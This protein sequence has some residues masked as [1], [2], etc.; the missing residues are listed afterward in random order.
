MTRRQ[1]AEFVSPG[2]ENVTVGGQ[3]YQAELV[4]LRQVLQ[5]LVKLRRHTV[6]D[7]VAVVDA[8]QS[9]GEDRFFLPDCQRGVLDS[10]YPCVTGWVYC[11][12]MAAPE[13]GPN[14]GGP[15][16]D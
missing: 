7:S 8:V 15:D 14:Q 13:S 6:V 2:R 9:D 1:P 3:H 11:L 10:V 5:R 12:K 4:L 16:L